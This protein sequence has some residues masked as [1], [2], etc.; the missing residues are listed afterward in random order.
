VPFQVIPRELAFFDLF[1]RAA[2]GVLRAVVDLAILLDDLPNAERHAQRIR[3]LEHEGD[4]LTH[5]IIALVN[6]TFVT[7]FDR[8][9][10]HR[11]AS[12]L[13]DVIDCVEGLADLLVLLRIAKPLPQFVQ[14]I[15]VLRRATTAVAQAVRELRSLHPL[16]AV[17]TEIKRAEREGDWVYRRGV[18]ELYS[19]D[20]EPMQVLMWKDLLHQGETALDKCE[21][22]ANTIESVLLKFA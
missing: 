5:Q 1:D 6:T 15:E 12:S 19:G 8:K 3:D 22:I 11:L 16:E 13:D 20:Y 21:D 10:M 14:Q 4:D 2:G 9:D 17:L 18:A 7:P